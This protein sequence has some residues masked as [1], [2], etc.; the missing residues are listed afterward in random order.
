MRKTKKIRFKQQQQTMGRSLYLRQ[1]S[2]LSSRLLPQGCSRLQEAYPLFSILKL[3]RG[4]GG[5]E[6][7]RFRETN[8]PDKS[9]AHAAHSDTTSVLPALPP[10]QHAPAEA[11]RPCGRFG[12]DEER[13]NLAYPDGLWPPQPGRLPPTRR[14]PSHSTRS[15]GPGQR[16]K[17]G[18]IRAKRREESPSRAPE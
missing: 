9:T 11:R 10:I 2:F 15:R 14:R 4:Q 1:C 18:L 5:P 8:E 6:G 13:P 16:W 12:P 17:G 3:P 7:S